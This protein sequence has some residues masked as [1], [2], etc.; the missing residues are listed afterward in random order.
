MEGDVE[1]VMKRPSGSSASAEEKA[2]IDKWDAWHACAGLG[3]TEAKRRYITTLIRTMHTYAAGT[4][5]ARALVEE[6]EFVWEQVKGNYEGQVAAGESPPRKVDT[7]SSPGNAHTSDSK[8]GSGLRVLRPMSDTEAPTGPLPLDDPNGDDAIPSE[9]ASFASA[10]SISSR[11]RSRS[12]APEADPDALHWRNRVSRA[13]VQLTAEVAALREL[14]DGSS[15]SALGRYWARARR[16]RRGWILRVLTVFW[17]LAKRML[18]D[19]AV[20]A[21]IVVLLRWKWRA[22]VESAWELLGVW[23][24]F[25]GDEVRGR[26]REGVREGIK[27][28]Q[29]GV[30]MIKGRREGRGSEGRSDGI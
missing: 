22:R 24:G 27:M 11:P 26:L 8:N 29:Q 14:A 23:L 15:T 30:G 6:L 2:E 1:G 28:G 13:L 12:P 17:K 21:L 4:P 19:A 7:R 20:V 18:V 9:H 16:R 10:R 25:V 5:E 3:K